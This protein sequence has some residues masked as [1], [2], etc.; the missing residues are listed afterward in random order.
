MLT[1]HLRWWL[2]GLGFWMSLECVA[3]AA[4]TNGVVR[5]GGDLRVREEDFNYIPIRADP[6]GVTRSGNNDY[7]RIRPRLWMEV[8]P[9]GDVTF[10]MR[11]AD[12]MRLWKT[13]GS[14]PKAQWFN[15]DPPD[16]I[17][18]D[19]LYLDI[20]H[21]AGDRLDLRV[22]RQDMAYGNGR[23]I[24]DG[25]PKDGSRTL[26]FNAIKATWKDIPNT[27]VDFLGIC[28]PSLDPLAI[29][30]VD[31]DVTGFTPS[32]DGMN[33]NGAGVYIKNRSLAG[34]PV[35]L[36]GFYKR[37]SPYELAAKKDA[38]GHFKTPSLAW[39]TL[40]S[41]RGVVLNPALDLGTV[42]FRV[43]PKLNARLTA[44]LEA[45]LQF[46]QRSD[47]SVM[48]YM[49]DVSVTNTLPVCESLKPGLFAEFYLLS[50]DDPKTGRDEG[51]NPLWARWPQNSELYVYAYDA[52]GAGRWSNLMMPT[53]GAYCM[54]FDWLKT[55]IFGS[56]L[57]A[58]AADGP[59]GGHERGWMGV[60]KG[61]FNLGQGW[62]S[63]SDALKGHL[64]M[65]LLRPGDYYKV[66]DTAY[67][68][69]WQLTYEF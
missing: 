51:W 50:G 44:N 20:R 40:D 55:T 56:H 11:L 12:E 10:R 39:Q 29:N 42:G 3:P 46:G 54:P 19:N 69:R 30:S 7:F 41:V 34:L 28:D 21:L 15:Y 59:G 18:F 57:S 13:P 67:F 32:N 48:A 14:H 1:K 31:R 22:G 43:E 33:E 16:E 17:V 27:T 60:V 64:W 6:P 2:A 24:L 65:E 9:V 47:T 66:G 53:I 4:Q 23:I 25:T 8:D 5:W 49:L 36:Y 58:P 52:D 61:E 37:E 68:L 62:V 63:K 38:A 26:Y 35:E 45:A